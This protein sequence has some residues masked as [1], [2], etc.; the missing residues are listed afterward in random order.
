MSEF[1]FNATVEY[2]ANGESGYKIGEKVN[3]SFESLSAD[4]NKA[5]GKTLPCGETLSA[6]VQVATKHRGTLGFLLEPENY[7]ETLTKIQDLIE[8]DVMTMEN[9]L[10]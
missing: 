7:A 10:S 9:L 5:F 6:S 4:I 2:Y 1:V 3:R 8:S